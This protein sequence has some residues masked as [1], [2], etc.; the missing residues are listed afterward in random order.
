[1]FSKILFVATYDEL[2]HVTDEIVKEYGLNIE[3]VSS[4]DL[5]DGVEKVKKYAN[6]NIEVVIC[7]GGTAK[8]IR[9]S[10]DIPVVEIEVSAYDLLRTIYKHKNKKMA[11]IGSDNVISGMNAL[12]QI[13][14]L[15]ISYFPVVLEEEIE[16]EV[17]IAC[18]IGVDIVIGDTVAVRVAKKR[19]IKYEL[20]KSGKE[21]ILSAI[22][23]AKKIYEAI[24][25]EREKNIRLNAILELSNEGFVVTDEK[26]QIIIF[27]DVAQKIFG[28][29]KEDAIGKDC[30]TVLPTINVNDIIESGDCVINHIQKVKDVVL[31]V[32]KT[33]IFVEGMI[34]GGVIAFSD[35]TKIQ[36]LEQKI[37]RTLATQ[38]LVA[39]SK[40][41]DIIGDSNSIKSTIKMSLKYAKV[42]STILIYGESGTGKEMFA[43]SIHNASDRSEGPFIAINCAAL[44]GSLL[45]SKLFGYDEG[46]FT[47]ATK[48][49]KKGMFEL[50]HNGTLFLDE[51]GEMDINVQA[52]ILRVLQ[53]KEIMRLGGERM[54]LINVRIIA[55][56]N[57]RLIDEVN[58]SK[59]RED[60]FYRLNIL[61]IN[62]PSLHERKEDIF[63]LI[64]YFLKY[65]SIAYKKKLIKLDDSVL[66]LLMNYKWPG[67]VRQ[68]ENVVEKMVVIAEDSSLDAEYLQNLFCEFNCREKPQDKEQHYEGDFLDGSLEEINIR[69]VKKVL[70]QESYNKTRTA[71]R[72]GI[73]RV[74]LNKKLENICKTYAMY[75]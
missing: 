33:P 22:G 28:I 12:E 40:F 35:V 71:Q 45:E 64:R 43:Q 13:M 59:F 18:K 15:S 25:Q 42:D 60:L 29:S 69:I 1:M 21:A 65:Y 44:P 51:I 72:L 2:K 74:T 31:A 39:K 19:G 41:E 47:G 5:L 9:N 55:A 70:E 3:V 30:S 52:K 63:I 4:G 14:D 20:I 7:R 23:E 57:K 68:L 32:N 38:R 24:L 26:K 49:G 34:K 37:R 48:G 17:D 54:I 27:N 50:A 75:N 10:I 8:L 46:A 6:E 53:E 11:V 61:N 66:N 56:S 36:E 16:K 58:M 62:I 73:T 67:N